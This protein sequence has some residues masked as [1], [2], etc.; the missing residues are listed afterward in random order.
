M[1]YRVKLYPP[2][3]LNRFSEA[4]VAMKRQGTVAELMVHLGISVDEV[5]S[6]YINGH[7]GT[8]EQPLTDGDKV[9]FLPLIGGG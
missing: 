9:T 8:F 6:V 4:E 7:G 2:L 5:G 3:T 1:K